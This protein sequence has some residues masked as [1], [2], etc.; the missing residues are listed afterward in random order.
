MAP[1]MIMVERGV[2]YD[3]KVDIW[4]VGCIVFEMWTA[5]RPWFSQTNF[6][7]V[8]EK[9]GY[10]SDSQSPQSFL[11]FFSS[12]HVKR[13]LRSRQTSVYVCLENISGKNVSTRRYLSISDVTEMLIPFYRD[14]AL[15]P[16]AE[17][18][19]IHP[20]LQLA[21]G[22]MFP[23]I[24]DMG[25]KN[26][27]NE[28]PVSELEAVAR[29]LS[30]AVT[31][32]S[33]KSSS[34]PSS[35]AFTMNSNVIVPTR[36]ARQT[37]RRPPSPPLVIIASPPPRRLPLPQSPDQSVDRTFPTANKSIEGQSQDSGR[38][39]RKLNLHD[40]KTV[41][42][43]SKPKKRDLP[44][45]PIAQPFVY[46]PPELPPIGAD[47]PY[48]NSLAPVPKFIPPPP[49]RKGHHEKQKS[50]VSFWDHDSSS[51]LS[52]P[53]RMPHR[54]GPANLKD[55]MSHS[56]SSHVRSTDDSSSYTMSSSYSG[57]QR[58]PPHSA[59]APIQRRPS[60]PPIPDLKAK[61]ES[62]SASRRQSAVFAGITRPDNRQVLEHMTVYFPDHDLDEPLVS[63]P[64]E[65]E[66]AKSEGVD[67]DI[68]PERRFTMRSIKSIADEE[69]HRVASSPSRRR[70]T[71]LWGSKIEEIKT[72]RWYILVV[73]PDLIRC[74]FVAHDTSEAC[75]G[76]ELSL[77]TYL[78]VLNVT[79]QT[80]NVR[81]WVITYTS[82]WKVQHGSKCRSDVHTLILR[83]N[84]SLQWHSKMRPSIYV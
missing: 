8:I 9:V 18:L 67:V 60:L 20:Y 5:K 29:T 49:V 33:S 7:Q 44:K 11:N 23:G 40:P 13:H 65:P 79:V 27:V 38:P 81:L 26:V 30:Q 12:W 41:P 24:N 55:A 4:S 31:I 2:G 15:R 43:L 35:P 28:S 68:I 71:R 21:P 61:A 36:A 77:F 75:I 59:P 53:S 64:S 3:S 6:L 63:S 17:M 70:Q 47:T 84:C 72:Y 50:S 51:T 56:G 52:L 69:I 54:M 39:Q 19:L 76:Y 14:P 16:T 10:N 57:W 74:S 42:D 80:F 32:E 34:R 66:F 46:N 82:P 25:N 1:E 78:Y 22:W 62:S 58:P 37:P 83:P 48:S 73:F 45:P